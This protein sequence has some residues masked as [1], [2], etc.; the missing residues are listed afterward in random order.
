[1]RRCRTKKNKKWV[2][3]IQRWP[4][5]ALSGTWCILWRFW[6]QSLTRGPSVNISFSIF[7]LLCRCLFHTMVFTCCFMTLYC[8]FCYVFLSEMVQ[9]AGQL[10]ENEYDKQWNCLSVVQLTHFSLFSCP[11][12]ITSEYWWVANERK[13]N[14]WLGN[15]YNCSALLYLNSTFNFK[16]QLEIYYTCQENASAR[17]SLVIWRL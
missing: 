16:M 14:K 3:R 10:N 13:K 17:P 8:A 4:R 7:F 5:P 2:Q 15:I 9:S 6:T 11:S 12:L 1:M